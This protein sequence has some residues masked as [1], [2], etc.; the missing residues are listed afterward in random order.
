MRKRIWKK[1]LKKNFMKSLKKKVALKISSSFLNTSFPGRF[2]SFR[3]LTFSQRPRATPWPVLGSSLLYHLSSHPPLWSGPCL[4]SEYEKSLNLYF[5]HQDIIL[6]FDQ[7][8]SF[9]S[10][11]WL[12]KPNR[13]VMGEEALESSP[14]LIHGTALCKGSS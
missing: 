1:K 14:I 9:M 6:A 7:L 13:E 2:K 3:R 5:D 10:L 8:I 12:L 4:A 11:S